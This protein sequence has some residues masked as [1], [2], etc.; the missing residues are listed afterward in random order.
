MRRA[1]NNHPRA[2]RRGFTLVELLSVIAIIGVLA[3]IIIVV[4]GNM[5]GKTHSVRCG[6]NIRQVQSLALIWAKDNRDWV[7]QAMWFMK[8]IHKSRAGATNLRSVGYTD[9]LGKCPSSEVLAPNYGINSKLV[10]GSPGGQ[11]WGDNYTQYYE[12]G[13]YKYSQIQTASTIVFAETAKVKDW[14]FGGAAAYMA[15]NVGTTNTLGARHDG[16]AW[17]AYAD[18]HIE[19]KVPADIATDPIWAKGITN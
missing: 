18:G 12:H 13:R 6:S 2:S 16:K 19:L 17:V 1:V 3:A 9:E 11:Q 15:I 8:D 7:P 14:S 4:V 5:R 10:Q